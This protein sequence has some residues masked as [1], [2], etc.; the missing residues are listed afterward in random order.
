MERRVGKVL[1]REMLGM[2][3]SPRRPELLPAAGQWT[4]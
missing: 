1:F 2:H 4:K 3:I